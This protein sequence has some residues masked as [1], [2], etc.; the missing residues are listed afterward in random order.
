MIIT[1]AV[2]ERQLSMGC[3]KQAV[4]ERPMSHGAQRTVLAVLVWSSLVARLHMLA[5]SGALNVWRPLLQRTA[6]DVI[7]LLFTVRMHSKKCASERPPNEQGLVT[8]A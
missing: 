2:D 5:V 8:S 4:D 1:Q 3:P 7:S 6:V